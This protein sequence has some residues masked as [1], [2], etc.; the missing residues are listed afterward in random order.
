MDKRTLEA[1]RITYI[2]MILQV[3]GKLISGYDIDSK[4]ALV[5]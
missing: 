4:L 2:A 5:H 3:N 1:L